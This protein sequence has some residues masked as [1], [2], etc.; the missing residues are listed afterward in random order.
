MTVSGGPDT[1]TPR[2][3]W[4]HSTQ[5]EAEGGCF[6]GQG[7]HVGYEK[8]ILKRDSYSRRAPTSGHFWTKGGRTAGEGSMLT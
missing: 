5:E 1:Q 3:A 7:A 4:P 6:P 2:P 8:G